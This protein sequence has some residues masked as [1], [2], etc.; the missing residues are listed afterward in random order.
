VNVGEYGVIYRLDTGYDMSAFTALTLTFT[1]PDD[2]VM[3]RTNP[4]VALGMVNF[5]DPVLGEFL[6]FQYV[7]YTFAV[8]EVDVGGTWEVYLTYDAGPGLRLFSTPTSKFEVN[9]PAC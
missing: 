6:A 8:G 9:N 1:K 4:A 2:T 7:T 3:V 5:A